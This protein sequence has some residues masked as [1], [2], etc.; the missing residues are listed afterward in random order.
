MFV[1]T[2]GDPE[3][4]LFT[5]HDVERCLPTDVVLK[6]V[7]C[8]G[9]Q[10]KDV[11][12]TGLKGPVLASLP[13]TWWLWRIDERVGYGIVPS[14][15]GEGDEDDAPYPVSWGLVGDIIGTSTAYVACPGVDGL[16]TVGELQALVSRFAG[17]VFFGPI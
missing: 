14:A 1:Y 8:P 5:F 10:R 15:L 4:Q 17:Y 3:M 7:G 2:G 6:A 9:I 11:I 12:A 13:T 16:A